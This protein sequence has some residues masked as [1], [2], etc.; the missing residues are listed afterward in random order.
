[1]AKAIFTRAFNYSSRTRNAGWSV[2]PGPKPQTYPQELID[3][4]VAAGAATH[5]KPARK[6][7]STKE[8]EN[9]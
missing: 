8:A 7:A 4:A 1:M 9:G 6:G 3:A 2:K 5:V